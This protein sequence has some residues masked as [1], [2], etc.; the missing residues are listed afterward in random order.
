MSQYVDGFVLPVLTK[1]LAAYREMAAKAAL[2]FRE[3]GALEVRECFCEDPSGSFALS[4]HKGIQAREDETVVFSWISYASREQRDAVNAK[5]MADPRMQGLC[6]E[7]KESPFDCTRMLYGGF[8][9][10]V[11]A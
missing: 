4:F 10:V 8:E 9:V 7:G 5:I 3:H 2:L 6:G 1:N 11:A